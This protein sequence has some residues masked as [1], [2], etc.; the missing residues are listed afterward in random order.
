MKRAIYPLYAAADESR[1]RPILEA[2][3][4]EGATIRDRKSDP[5]KRDALLL[6]LSK[7]VAADGP[8]A[9]AFFR[10]SA[11]RALVIPVNLDGSTPPETLQNALMARHTL[12]GA[13]Y[14][15]EE[16][17]ERIVRPVMGEGR[18][19]LPLVLSLAAA[20]ILLL[21][22][23]I[24]LWKNRPQ[25][26]PEPVVE[27]SPA[28]T[29]TQA[30][31]FPETGDMTLEQ[32]EKVFELIIVGD[33]FNY[34]TGEEEW[35]MG[36]GNA[37]VGVEHVA[38]R[39][40]ENGEARWYSAEDGHA[41][42]LYDWGD[43]SFLPYM[44]NLGLLTLV[45]VKGQLPDLSGLKKLGLVE[46]FDCDIADISGVKDSGITAFGY[47]G[48]VVD[49]S[50]LNDCRRL[51]SVNLSI[52]GSADM[53][54]ATFSPPAL[55][56]LRLDGQGDE[57]SI[58]LSSLKQCRKLERVTF[59]RLPLTD[60]S[61][62]SGTTVLGAL[63]L[64]DLP[65]LTSLDGLKNVNR[66]L[67][68]N[69]Y[70]D[71]CTALRDLDALSSCIG[72][73]ELHIEDCPITDLSFLTGAKSLKSLELRSM[74]SL[75]SFKGL[76]DHRN[77]QQ[78]WVVD[79][80]NL[81]DI[82]ALGSCTNLES[83]NM[84]EVFSLA[85]ISPIVKL[86]KLRDLQIYGSWLND[87]N[88]LWDIQDKEYFSF[89]IAEV[90]DWTGLSAIQK[91]NYLNVTDRSGSA[92]PY[93]QD[94]TVNDLEIWNRG[95]R[96]NQSEGMDLSLLPHVTNELLLHCVRSLEGLDQ[97]DARRLILDDC[98]YLASLAGLEGM[99]RMQGL[100]ICNCPRLND[101]SALTGRSIYEI[102]LEGLFSLPDF[103]NVV[104]K[105][106]TLTTI[107]DLK[108]L[109]CFEN[110]KQ[111]WYN[112]SLMDVD[113]VTD[114]SP[115]YH[116]KG[117]SLQVPAHLMEQ[118][119]A[120]VDS[121]L[122]EAYE[123]T[124]PEGWWQPIEPDVQLASIDEIDTLPS[125]LLSRIRS[126]TL[127]GDAVVP[128]E[129]AHVEEDWSTDPPTLYVRY[130]GEEDRVPVEPGTL[131]DLGCLEKLTG[132]EGLT[133][134]A[135]PQLTS[136]AGMENMDELKR[137]NVIQ[138]PALTDGSAAF[139]VQSLEELRFQYTGVTSIQ[140]IQN[141]YAL[142]MLDL[143]GNPVADLSPLSTL[144]NLEDVNFE[145]PM[146]PFAELAALPE[147]VR[148]HV[149]NLSI[150]G[151]YVYAGGPWWFEE[152]WVTDPPTLY[153]HSNETDERLPL[154]D[155][156][157]TDM[158]SLA[159]L[160][161]GLENLD[162]YAQPLTTL[163]GIENFSGL[164]RLT[165]EE[166]RQIEDFSALWNLASLGDISLRNEP[167][168]SLEGVEK[169]THLVNL[170]LS[171]AKITDFSPLTR[172]DYSYCT[173]EEY[174]GWGF[175]LALDVWNTD[176]FTYEDYAVLE[177]VP[178]YWSLNVNNVAVDRWLG[179]VMDKELHELSCHG[180]GISN[181]QLRAFVAAHPMLERLDLRWNPQLTDL[182][183]LRELP[184]DLRQLYL[185]SNMAQAADSLGEGYGF[186][187]FKEN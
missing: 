4:K 112:I 146:M 178:V 88:F 66:A 181:E 132:L 147:G 62:L 72:L 157:V 42:A 85:D 55:T 163:D 105:N 39:N 144:S 102:H 56:H 81:T 129:N 34:Y 180:S 20:A 23:G 171:G 53:D 52:Y 141:L 40:F 116:L 32:M 71:N 172:V 26:E 174:Y 148:R 44:K 2:L 89:G 124:Y 100:E 97:P 9:D 152:D 173:S 125:A 94:A 164:W 96:G 90:R 150:A 58:D 92:L 158:G 110:Y 25:P 155:G 84:H 86:P 1:V 82:S 78:I 93:I 54:M 3:R 45:N 149:R 48:P 182:S 187:L 170:S 21:A 49:F 184:N 87:V 120:M 131:T 134:Y 186:A 15:P 27:A 137:L 127:A 143:N 77:L 57:R 151:E 135:Q 47:Y 176:Q 139:T 17:A 108:D 6:F 168:D 38:N 126:L 98:P 118:A 59:E 167:I 185:S 107:F 161:P 133:V 60:L 136:L 140:G 162:L 67:L 104:T 41:F 24:A 119:Q 13:K 109:S 36:S 7:N 31:V 179:H 19:R 18:N 128:D 75:R 114:L 117:K 177:A 145:L 63:D 74:P 73:G 106:I 115:L 103:G 166:C 169:L 37:R 29:P 11:G 22:G 79:L 83:L 122:L 183:C 113:G 121:G 64:F 153:L 5:G 46:L 76:E 43:L 70:I 130:D 30:P 50:P 156:A 33:S 91:Y 160:L 159:A 14:R 175:S 8:E 16:L 101:W 142:R 111:D 10:L 51:G 95:G 123:V 154:I 80:Q 99:P 68:G 165:I 69:V 65:R 138:C 28:P 35:M 12:D 61:F